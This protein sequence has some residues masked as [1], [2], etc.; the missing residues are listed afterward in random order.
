M[1]TYLKL[2][3]ELLAGFERIEV[4]HV[5]REEKS[6]VDALAN[7]GSSIEFS[8]ARANP[9]AVTQWPVLWKGEASGSNE[10]N[11]VEEEENWMS[12]IVKYLT[13]NECPLDKWK[14]VDWFRRQ[15][16]SR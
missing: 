8:S 10:V 7:L 15:P 16:G 11:P 3:K 4:E 1:I 13:E 5:S 9:F 12:P 6:H 14:Q 2:V